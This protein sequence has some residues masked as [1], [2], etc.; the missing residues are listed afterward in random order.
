LQNEYGIKIVFKNQNLENCM[1]TGY[2]D[3]ESIE[4]IFNVL[5]V[6]LNIQYRIENKTVYLSGS[7]CM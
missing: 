3:N 7:S 1:L 4:E 2:F 5:A 6:T